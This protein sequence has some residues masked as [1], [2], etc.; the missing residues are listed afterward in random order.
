MKT[1][2]DMLGWDADGGDE[3]LCATVDDDAHEL[4]ELSLSIIIAVLI[5]LSASAQLSCNYGKNVSI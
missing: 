2:D 3:E 5:V 1:V 4:V